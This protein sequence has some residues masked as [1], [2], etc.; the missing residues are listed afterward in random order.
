M[1]SQLRQQYCETREYI[2]SL[3]KQD[4]ILFWKYFKKCSPNVKA[5]HR[6]KNRETYMKIYVFVG[7]SLS[8]EKFSEF[9]ETFERMSKEHTKSESFLDF[10]KIFNISLEKIAKN[11][12]TFD[13]YKSEFAFTLLKFCELKGL[14]E[15]GKIL[16][17]GLRKGVFLK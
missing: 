11:C 5:L 6:R 15:D 13:E 4:K 17:K 7:S 1:A 9:H 3:D 10:L 2:H 16:R 14:A 12:R 8:R